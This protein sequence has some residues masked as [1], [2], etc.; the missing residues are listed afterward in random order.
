MPLA[1]QITLES[2]NKWFVDFVGPISPLEKKTAM[3]HI[4]TAKEYLT[5]WDE[6][7]PVKYCTAATTMKFLFENMLTIFG[8]PKIL[9]SD[10]GTHFVKKNI[11]E[12]TA[13]FQI[14]HRKTTPYHLQENGIVEAFNKIL[15]NAL[16]RVCNACRDDWDHKVSVVLWVYCTTCKR[17]S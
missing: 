13:E 4:I 16:I 17:L 5:R 7:A 15:E 12:L 6:V 3:R 9:L 10:Q 11:D 14:Q 2:F 1:P 8:F